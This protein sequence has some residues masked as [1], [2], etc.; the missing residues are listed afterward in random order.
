MPDVVTGIYSLIFLSSYFLFDFIYVSIRYLFTQFIFCS[1]AFWLQC[2]SVICI[3]VLQHEF[4]YASLGVGMSVASFYHQQ[5]HGF[6]FK[7]LPW[8]YLGYI[9]VP[10][11]I[12]LI[13]SHMGMCV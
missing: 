10:Y 13:P 4:L 12:D 1:S 5:T 7:R 9:G 11:P 2:E 8:L 6:C 3:S